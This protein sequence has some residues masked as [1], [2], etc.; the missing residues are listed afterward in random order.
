MMASKRYTTEQ[1]LSI[2]NDSDDELELGDIDVRNIEKDVDS[3]Y[4]VTEEPDYAD[5][6]GSG[7]LVPNELLSVE[8]STALAGF[9]HAMNLDDEPA[10]RDSLLPADSDLDDDDSMDNDDLGDVADMDAYSGKGE[11]DDIK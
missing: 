10:L 1:L 3:D 5:S 11:N 7:Q 8:T 4:G 6:E 9:L 2:V